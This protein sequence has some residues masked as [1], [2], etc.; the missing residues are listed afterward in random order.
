MPFFFHLILFQTQDEFDEKKKQATITHKAQQKLYISISFIISTSVCLTLYVS[1]LDSNKF[2]IFLT[3]SVTIIFKNTS[4]SACC[5]LLVVGCLAPSASLMDSPL[6]HLL[7]AFDKKPSKII[8]FNRFRF[9][10][11]Y[12]IR[13]VESHPVNVCLITWNGSICC[14]CCNWKKNFVFFFHSTF[15]LNNI[16]YTPIILHGTKIYLLR[17]HCFACVHCVYLCNIFMRWTGMIEWNA[18]AH[19]YPA[20]IVQTAIICCFCCAFGLSAPGFGNKTKIHDCD[21]YNPKSIYSQLDV[22]RNLI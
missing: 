13:R 10:L 7:Y 21:F 2:E 20:A 15:I 12:S 22:K 1:W 11:S 18:I 17:L 19:L 16:N 5:L 4:Q 14:C 8:V 3:H 9:V 6:C